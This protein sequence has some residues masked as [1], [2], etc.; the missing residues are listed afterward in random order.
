[1]Q[2]SFSHSALNPAF[3]SSPQGLDNPGYRIRLWIL[4]DHAGSKPTEE[5][6]H[7]ARAEAGQGLV[8]QTRGGMVGAGRDGEKGSD[9]RDSKQ[10]IGWS[11]GPG[12]Y[13][14]QSNLH[15]YV[16]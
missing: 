1:M 3:P 2:L 14:F 7:G 11:V 15:L 6:R 12:L 4:E 10:I 16:L 8:Q 5:M 13:S 9:V